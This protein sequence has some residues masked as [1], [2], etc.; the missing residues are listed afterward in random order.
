MFSILNVFRVL[1]ALVFLYFDGM[2]FPAFRDGFSQV[3]F[4]FG[5]VLHIRRMDVRSRAWNT[6]IFRRSA[7]FG[8]I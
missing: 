4:G 1:G 6:S 3:F 7:M 2:A 5:S 8:L